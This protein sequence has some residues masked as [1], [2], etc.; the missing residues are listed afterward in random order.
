MNASVGTLGIGQSGTI[1]LT[2]IVGPRNYISFTPTITL[3][4]S[5]SNISDSVIIQEPMVCGD[6]LLTRNEVCDTQGQLGVIISGQVCENQQNTC[7]LV[8]KYI[9]NTACLTYQVGTQTG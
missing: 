4:S 3:S 9:V 8:T 1:I 6:G 7:V 5:V 2:G